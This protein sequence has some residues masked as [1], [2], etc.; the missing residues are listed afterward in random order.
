MVSE[1]RSL[2]GRLLVATPGLLDPNFARTVV[3]VL[4]HDPEGAVGLVL[5]RPT[6]ADL[7]DHVPVWWEVAAIPKVVFVGGPVGEGG[8]VALGRG[9]GGVDM[10][11]WESVLG[12][13]VIDL[14]SEPEDDVGLDLRVFAGYAGWGPGQLD[15]EIEVG[16]WFVVDASADDAFTPEPAGLWSRVLA[17]AGGKYAIV[18]TYPPDPRLN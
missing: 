8:A 6:K 3:L 12:L 2:A 9:A 5:N 11:G 17:R 1:R 10:E 4:E 7:L 13:R 15:E 16:G 18:A 14:S